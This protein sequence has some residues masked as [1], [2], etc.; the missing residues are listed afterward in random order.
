MSEIIAFSGKKQSGKTTAANFMFGIS[1]QQLQLIDH[2]SMSADG[3]LVVPTKGG[4]YETLDLASTPRTLVPEMVEFMRNEVW[5]YIK[6]YN[7]AEPLKDYMIAVFGLTWEQCY[8][9]DDQKNTETEYLWENMP[10]KIKGKKGKMLARELV[11]YWGTEVMRSID[12]NIWVRATLNK[13]KAENPEIAIIGDCRF[14]NEVQGILD[15]DG[16]VYRLTKNSESKDRHRSETALDKDKFDW[17]IFTKVLEN[18]NITIDEQCDNIFKLMVEAKVFNG[19]IV[20]EDG[21][22]QGENNG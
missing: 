15:V 3:K 9:T 2:F 10:V 7:F 1:L 21:V 8:G 11:Q 22:F 14:P 20:N 12:D 18:E 6:V 4:K 16:K 19:E 13:I 5:P 17:S